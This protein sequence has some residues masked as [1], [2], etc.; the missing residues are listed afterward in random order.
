M[1]NTPVLWGWVGRRSLLKIVDFYVSV[2]ELSGQ[3]AQELAFHFG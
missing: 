3:G 1:C 2:P